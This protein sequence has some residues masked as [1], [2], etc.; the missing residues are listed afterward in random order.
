LLTVVYSVIADFSLSYH[1]DSYSS[2]LCC[3]LCTCQ[4]D[5]YS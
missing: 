2:C 5:S 4:C 1:C 3:Q